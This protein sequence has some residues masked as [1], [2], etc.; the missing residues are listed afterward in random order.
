MIG[1]DRRST[2]HYAAWVYSDDI[3]YIYVTAVASCPISEEQFS[4]LS[5]NTNYLKLLIEPFDHMM[6]HTGKLN[7]M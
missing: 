4:V 5:L 1:A 7:Y 2:F 3:L 6:Q